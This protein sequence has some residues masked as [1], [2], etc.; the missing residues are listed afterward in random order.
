M[1][2]AGPWVLGLVFVWLSACWGT[3]CQA[4]EFPVTDSAALADIVKEL[5]PGDEVVFRDGVWRDIDWICE[6]QGTPES[7]ITFRPQTPGGVT[8]SGHSRIRISGTGVIVRGFQFAGAWHKSAMI[9]FRRD[10]KRAA[11]GCQL[12]DCQIVDCN[13]P[14]SKIE[15]KYV[16]IYGRGNVVRNGRF[17]GKTNRGATMVVWLAEGWT[18]NRISQNHF[19]PRPELGRNGGETIRIGDSETAHLAAQVL[20]DGN[21]LERCD[22]E[23]EAIS[24]KSCENVYRNNLFIECSGTLTLRHGHRC[25]VTGNL[26]IGNK[27]RGSGGVRIIGRDHVVTKNH[28]ESLEGDR[29]RSGLCVV[30]GI[31]DSPANGYDPVQRAI[32]KDNTFVQCKRSIHFGADN[33]AKI[34][35]APID[36]DVSGNVI[37]S[38]RGP[39]IDVTDPKSLEQAS[40]NRFTDNRCFGEGPVGID[41]EKVVREPMIESVQTR[42]E[43]IEAAAGPSW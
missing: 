28:F 35:I 14:D 11:E 32:V 27:A 3:A 8:I 20:V 13:P 2:T 34:Q 36:C 6:G 10:S 41:L 4:R 24:N 29:F 33:D 37:V 22:G 25:L 39:M 18:G 15:S 16:S 17:S 31:P 12:V 26:F 19:G 38:R 9:E 40:G 42:A 30:N 21:V 5:K 1:T 23:A 7:A 43:A